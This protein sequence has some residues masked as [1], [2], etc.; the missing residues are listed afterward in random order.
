MDKRRKA[1]RP[2]TSSGLNED[3]EVIISESSSTE[4]SISDSPEL[5]PKKSNLKVGQKRNASRKTSRAKT[6][7]GSYEEDEDQTTQSTSNEDTNDIIPGLDPKKLRDIKKR[8]ARKPETSGLSK[9]RKT[10]SKDSSSKESSYDENKANSIIPGLNSHGPVNEGL[11]IL[12]KRPAKQDSGKAKSSSAKQSSHDKN[13]ANSIIPGLKPHVSPLKE[14]LRTSTKLKSRYS[15]A[16][17]H[18]VPVL[19][20][21]DTL[22][23]EHVGKHPVF[24]RKRKVNVPKADSC[25][26][27]TPSLKKAQSRR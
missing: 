9:T 14:N 19:T 16:P 2:G 27:T 24:K 10:S 12:S 6:S 3:E 4:E 5:Q 1:T 18:V 20:D 11:R 21:N 26:Q 17:L 23:G 22:T 15:M 8:T 25:T 7:S 13:E